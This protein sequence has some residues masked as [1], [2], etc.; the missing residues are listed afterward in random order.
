MTSPE[1]H[2]A[3]MDSLLKKNGT[4]INT[5]LKTLAPSV[6]G[7]DRVRISAFLF[8]HIRYCQ[9]PL[10]VGEINEL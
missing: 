7:G 1:T 8:D 4:S 3:R 10:P 6:C 2:S 5:S 9:S